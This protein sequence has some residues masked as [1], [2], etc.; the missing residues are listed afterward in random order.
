MA[1]MNTIIEII[2]EIPKHAPK[3]LKI[4]EK[5]APV[6]LEILL[7]LKDIFASTPKDIKESS[8]TLSDLDPLDE[9]NLDQL[10]LTNALLNSLIN[11]MLT[12]IQDLES[13][14]LEIYSINANTLADFIES[15]Q[16]NSSTELVKLQI[17]GIVKRNI[18]TNISTSNKDFLSIL[19]LPKGEAKGVKIQD[20]IN[21]T[22]IVSIKQS[23]VILTHNIQ[24]LISNIKEK[25]ES[26]LTGQVKSLDSSISFLQ[27]IQNASNLAQKQTAQI[28]L[29]EKIF[30][31]SST[32]LNLS[33]IR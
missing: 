13:K 33:F 10:M 23:E 28:T 14:L 11:K 16:I 15:K 4:I 22:L 27:E 31:E 18:L 12:Q 32:L 25:I 24:S 21:E 8:K 2:K 30:I 5:Y 19:K 1:L 17:D 9:N 29:A 7:K 26:R 6:I 20:Y 3:I